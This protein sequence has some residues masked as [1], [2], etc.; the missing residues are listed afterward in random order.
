MS[1]L[2]D[3]S[4]NIIN[5]NGGSGTI[6]IT[7][8]QGTSSKTVN[9]VLKGYEISSDPVTNYGVDSTSYSAVIEE[10]RLA[11]MTEYAGDVNKIPLIIWTD[12]H[13]KRAALTGAFTQ[14]GATQN[15]DE[16]SALIGLGDNI[17]N[18]EAMTTDLASSN[19]EAYRH[20]TIAIPE[21]KKIHIIGNHDTYESQGVRHQDVAWINPYFNNSQFGD[22]NIKFGKYGSEVLYDGQYNVKYIS[23]GNWVWESELGSW[24]NYY[25]DKESLDDIIFNMSKD[26]GY[27]IVILSHVPILDYSGTVTRWTA[28]AEGTEGGGTEGATSIGVLSSIFAQNAPLDA[29]IE[30]RKQHTSGTILDSYG[31]T[32]TFDFSNTH[33]NVICSLHGHSHADL[34]SFAQGTVNSIVFDGTTQ[35]YAPFYFVL[36]DRVNDQLVAYKVRKTPNYNRY[37]IPLSP[38]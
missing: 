29:L 10:A 18:Y 15:F 27:D 37:V 6:N 1:T 31:N 11:W 35:S 9:T 22:G 16:M 34:Y 21:S 2:Y 26:D 3:G 13:A 17:P 20:S 14:I 8:R 28:D 7:V 38:Q 23:I 30:G 36:I 25:I 24:S 33:S 32:H 5:V 4:G 19:L 12:P